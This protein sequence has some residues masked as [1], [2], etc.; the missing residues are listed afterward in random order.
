MSF[1]GFSSYYR[2]HLKDFATLAKSL[3][4]V[5]DQKKVFEM[6]QEMNKAY[7]K[8]RKILAEEPLLLIPDWDIPF[9]LYINACGDG[10][11]AA[12]HQVQ[13]IADKPTE[14]P[15]RYISRQIKTTEARYGVSN[16]QGLFLVFALEKLHSYL[17]GSVFEVITHCNSVKSLL[18]MKNPNRHMLRWKIAIQEYR[19]NKTIA[20]KAGNIHKNSDGLS[21]LEL[22]NNP[23]SPAYVPLEAEPHI[24]I[25]GINITDIGNEFLE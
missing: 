17:D 21:R 12:L 19:G 24:P 22:G 3:Y 6:K 15:D 18:N 2:P 8:I 23:D 5:C 25:E 13:I 20:H 4:R 16:M 14:G 10:L 7:R 1:L 11:G 9:K